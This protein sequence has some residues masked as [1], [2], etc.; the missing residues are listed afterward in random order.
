MHAE[1]KI[2]D[3]LVMLRTTSQRSR[4]Y[5]RSAYLRAAL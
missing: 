4:S 3:S 1:V 2:G 5:A